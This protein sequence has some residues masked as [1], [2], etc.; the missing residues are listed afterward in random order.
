H[1]G[2]GPGSGPVLVRERLLPY[3]PV[4]DIVRDGDTYRRTTERP[5]SIGRI[6]GFH[7]NVAVLVRAFAYLLFMGRDGLVY[8]SE[9]AV[10]NANYL[11][12]KISGLLR[13]PY[14]GGCKHE[15]VASAKEIREEFGVSAL[16]I[17]KRIIDYGFHPPTMYFPL[18]VK[19]AL[20]IE[21]TE[22]ESKETLDAFAEVLG[23]IIEEART[24]PSLLI[25]APRTTPVGRLDEAGAARN[26]VVGWRKE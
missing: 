11:K 19:E 7:G 15:F 22:T 20:M 13:L 24:D 2:G 12:K 17:A 14:P 23:S 3:L 9:Q 8:A 5:K 4:P 18:I 6:A 26:P 21:P 25:K 1:G 10:L 16:D